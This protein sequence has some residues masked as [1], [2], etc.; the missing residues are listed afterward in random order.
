MEQSPRWV[1]GP[2][3]LQFH[4]EALAALALVSFLPYKSSLL[5]RCRCTVEYQDTGRNLQLF[6]DHQYSLLVRFGLMGWV[7]QA[8][9]QP[10]RG[11][12]GTWTTSKPT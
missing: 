12:M 7:D 4:E 8:R 1:V 5:A 10:H 9:V 2:T 11:L 6:N 3:S